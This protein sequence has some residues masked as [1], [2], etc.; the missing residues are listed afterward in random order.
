M[1]RWPGLA[2][3]VPDGGCAL[4]MP[5]VLQLGNGGDGGDVVFAHVQDVGWVHPL[6]LDGGE[7]FACA[8]EGFDDQ[9]RTKQPLA[10][11]RGDGE[12]GEGVE[13]QMAHGAGDNGQF[14]GVAGERERGLQRDA[15]VVVAAAVFFFGKGDDG[16]DVFG[17]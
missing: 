1:R 6:R 5:D 14:A 11:E 12:R 4:Q 16:L 3:E 7:W 13:A 15:E 8:V 9:L 17:G 10:A 2:T